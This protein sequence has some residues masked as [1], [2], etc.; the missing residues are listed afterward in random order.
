[1]E[2]ESR[3]FFIDNVAYC[4]YCGK[5]A[6]EHWTWHNHAPDEQYFN[7]DCKDAKTEIDINEKISDL[8]WKFECEINKI[9]YENMPKENKDIIRNM[10]Y[11][12][13]LKKLKKKFN[14]E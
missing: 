13:E 14:I 1:M 2:D 9:K 3:T 8:K 6:K 12:H 10:G 5:K 7:C 4:S 11:E